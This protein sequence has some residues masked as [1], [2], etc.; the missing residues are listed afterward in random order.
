[1]TQS[2]ST[3]HDVV[4]LVDPLPLRRAGLEALLADWATAEGLTLRCAASPPDPA[5]AAAVRLFLISAGGATPADLDLSAVVGAMREAAPDAA[6]GLLADGVEPALVRAA[7][8]AGAD[9]F[10]PAWLEPATVLKAL[11]FVLAGGQ[12]FPPQSIVDVVDDAPVR[13][14]STALRSLT[15]RQ[16]EIIKALRLGHANKVIARRLNISEATVKIHVRQIMRKLGVRN[17]TQ[18]ALS[19]VGLREEEDAPAAGERD[20]DAALGRPSRSRESA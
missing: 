16:Q 11:S 19:A 4:F 15:T 12:C 6:V 17:R 7:G 1:M 14:E 13:A 18:V 8:A 2:G 3:S 20:G 10:I 5:A 9:A